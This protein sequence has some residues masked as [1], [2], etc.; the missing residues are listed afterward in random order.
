MSTPITI[1]KCAICGENFN[2]SMEI[3]RRGG[4]YQTGDADLSITYGNDDIDGFDPIGPCCPECVETVVS[5]ISSLKPIK[6]SRAK[7]G[8]R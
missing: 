5:A 6:T 4:G 8:K 3:Y 1:E 2:L 7:K